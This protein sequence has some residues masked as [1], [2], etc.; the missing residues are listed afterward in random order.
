MNDHPDIDDLKRH[1][2]GKTSGRTEE[3]LDLAILRDDG[4][5]DPHLSAAI[6]EIYDDIAS[7]ALKKKDRER[8][9][10]RFPQTPERVG[11]LRFARSLS[12]YVKRLDLETA[13]KKTRSQTQSIFS[14]MAE[15]LEWGAAPAWRY[16]IAAVLV[17]SVAANFWLVTEWPDKGVLV[18]E[19]MT[20]KPESMIQVAR[21]GS[22]ETSVDST[23]GLVELDLDIG[24]Q[25]HVTYEA[26]I[27]RNGEKPLWTHRELQ[28]EE[29]GRTTIVKI[30]LPAEV[31]EP[32]RYQVS[33]IGCD[34][35]GRREQ[36]ES[37]SFS[38][39]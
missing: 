9:L 28:A 26:T 24:F 13:G 15:A 21:P 36:V 30:L 4:S 5:L 7:G 37:F 29:T 32:G 3:E 14:R 8:F 20:L 23:Q 6:G 33:L 10:E 1:L 16:A 25:E 35:D 17:A 39:N 19:T 27:S 34:E 18:A 38:V 2:L 11:Q 12:D 31:L 22:A